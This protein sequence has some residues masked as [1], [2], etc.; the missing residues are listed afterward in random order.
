MKKTNWVR[1]VA[2]IMFFALVAAITYNHTLAEQGLGISWLSNASVHAICPFG[3][4]TSIYQYFVTGTFVKKIHESSFVLMGLSFL[5]AILFGPVICGWVCPLGSIQEWF[6]LL[7]KKIF[8]NKYN[9]FVPTSL[10]KY[11]RYIRYFV[12]LWVI[13]V[14]ARAGTLVFSNIDPYSAMFHLFSDELAIGGLIV[15]I[16][17][18]TS[19][20]FIERPWCKYAC[21]Y[22]A[23]LGISN[24]FRVFKIKRDTNTCIDC[25]KCTNEC[26]MNIEVAEVEVVR[27]HQCISCMKC[28]SEEACPIENTVEFATGKS[29]ERGVK[30]EG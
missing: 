5:L 2:Q 11:L 26:P 14:T 13:Y 4:V 18:L 6:G 8:K 27:N 10:D 28:T 9:R 7:G 20:L 16:I 17:T 19:S 21:P 23:L 24:T 29:V 3:G 12:L 25:K 1:R 30:S 22:G 15:L